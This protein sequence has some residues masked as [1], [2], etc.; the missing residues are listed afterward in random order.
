MFLFIVGAIITVIALILTILASGKGDD[1]PP[2]FLA[3][4]TWFIGI[5]ILAISTV[6]T[7]SVGQASVI[8]NAG[9]TI[10]HQNTDPG[11]ATKA[12]WQ[13]RSEWNLFSQ[14]VTYAGNADEKPSYTGGEVAG[15]SITT[16]VSG[17]AQAEFDTS[18]VYSL[19]GERVEELFR[20][21][22]SQEQFTKQ[23][24]EPRILS[25]VRGIPSDYTAVDFRGKSRGAAQE[26]MLKRLNESLKD[27]GVTITLVNLQ[28]ITFTKEVEQSIKDVEVAQQQQAKAEAELR[29][30][31]ISA[32]AQVIEAEAKAQAAV[33]EAEGKAKANDI[34]S[35]S[36]TAKVLQQQWIDA[37]KAS[38][39]TIVVPDGAAPLINVPGGSK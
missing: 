21:F 22:R 39:G 13:K 17:G 24:V 1:R 36:L 14:S 6:Y 32:Q 38:G 27:Y 3:F 30:T 2:A 9:G 34:V 4:V 15:G 10:A 25:V 11:F 29:A 8:I 7:Q 37:I 28:N 18:I 12:P 16:S 5:G 20:E 19:D 33:A 23:V 26:A 35:N 31:E